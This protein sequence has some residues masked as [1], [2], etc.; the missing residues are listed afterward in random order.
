MRVSKTLRRWFESINLRQPITG[1]L[2]AHFFAFFANY[3]PKEIAMTLAE[4]KAWFDGFTESMDGPPSKKQW[5]RIKERVAQVN[6]EVLT[7]EVLYRDRYWPDYIRRW[8][9]Y[10]P[11][12]TSTV[13][14]TPNLT[15]LGKAE[16]QTAC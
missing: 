5:D 9:V 4:F 8:P 7:R 6:G 16:F 10:C 3:S 15:V 14:K 11:S 13:S 12:L 1:C 2:S